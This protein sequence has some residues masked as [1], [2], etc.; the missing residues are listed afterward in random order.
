[1]P[2]AVAPPRRRRRREEIEEEHG[3]AGTERW[4]VT[5]ADMLTLLFVLFVI[6]FS[7]SHIN[8]LKYQE[9]KEGL[10]AG[11]GQAKS[12]L[13]GQPSVLEGRT[14]NSNGNDIMAPG[15]GSTPITPTISDDTPEIRSQV[16]DQVQ[17]L[18]AAQTQRATADAQAQ[19]TD[20]VKLWQRIHQALV[21][22]GLE[23]DVQAS[24]DKRGLVISMVSR[25]VIFPYNL[26]GLTPRGQRIV[27]TVGSVI[28]K[29][30]EHIEID[31]ST[32]QQKVKPKYF[33]DDW[34]LAYARAH[35]VLSRLQHTD[36]LPAGRLE[37]MSFGHTH[38]LIPPTS[39]MAKE[40]N[41]RVDI[42]V[43]SSAPGATR[44]LYTAVVN[45]LPKS[46]KSLLTQPTI[47]GNP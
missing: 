15:I 3:T 27:D 29:I 22:E 36:G 19:V 26:A 44:D 47:G 13:T 17:E 31:G 41:K 40:I 33:Q 24:I 39:P 23:D 16:Q 2:R 1:M 35:T 20:L 12:L 5:Y 9:L 45:Q 46:Q 21:K 28:S 10:Q 32:N 4:L 18:M 14:S 6:L 38:P 43:L 34:D 25:H 8:Q 42:V 30:T 7:M 37:A 11:F